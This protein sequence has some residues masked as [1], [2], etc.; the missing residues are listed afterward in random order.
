[1]VFYIDN[2][3]NAAQNNLAASD[4]EHEIVDRWALWQWAAAESARLAEAEALLRENGG[5]ITTDIHDPK[6]THIIMDDGD[7]A[8]YAEISRK[9]ARCVCVRSR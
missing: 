1:L 7:S 9:T 6:L 5:R 4:P 8:R 2:A 3:A